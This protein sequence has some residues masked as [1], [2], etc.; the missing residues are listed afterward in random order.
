ML[1]VNTILQ[2]I[3]K[4]LHGYVYDNNYTYPFTE[5]NFPPTSSVDTL[6]FKSSQGDEIRRS[7]EN[8]LSLSDPSPLNTKLISSSP[9]SFSSDNFTYKKLWQAPDSEP[10]LTP[11]FLSSTCFRPPGAAQQQSGFLNFTSGSV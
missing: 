10:S 5:K 1:Y 7:F 9:T 6:A 4:T 11:V 3:T 2:S 8:Q